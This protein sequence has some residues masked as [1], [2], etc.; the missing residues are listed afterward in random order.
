MT[1]TTQTGA[2]QEVARLVA[3][4]R[5]LGSPGALPPW[6]RASATLDHVGAKLADA[7]L[8]RGI[9]YETGVRQR[10]ERFAARYPEAATTSGLLTLLASYGAATILDMKGGPKP[11]T[12]E[13]LAKLLAAERVESVAD[14]QTFLSDRWR[15]NRL[16]RVP[17]VGAK[18]VAFL[19]LIVGLDAVAVDMHILA[20]LEA[21]GVPPCD[22]SEVETLFA[23]AA[24]ELEMR[25]ADVD[26]LIWRH[27]S[28][29]ARR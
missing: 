18:T 23:Q 17:G 19:K 3:Y 2:D 4:V 5:T 9:N 15:A 20:A 11:A 6:G 14:L 7:T 28:G 27:Q 25:M 29:G 10:V 26:A 24:A 16:R 22:P 13:A 1:T 21:A 8:Q 12:F